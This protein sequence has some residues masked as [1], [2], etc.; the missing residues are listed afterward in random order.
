VK[1]QRLDLFG[2]KSFADRVSISFHSGITAIVGPNGCG[3]SNICDAIRWVLGEQR[4]TLVRGS[5]MD[6]VIFAGSRERKPINVAEIAL[7]FS[8]E[9]GTLPIEYSEVTIARRIF[10]G[11]GE[12]EYLLNRQPCRLK[13]VQ[14]L[15]LGTGIGTH[16]YSLIQQGMIDAVLSDRTEERRVLFEEAA[17]VTRYKTR[18]KATERKLEATTQDLLRVE[19][20][21][22]E[23][24]KTVGGLK[25]QVGKARRWREYEAEETR[26]DVHVADRDLSALGDRRAPLGEELRGLESA[27]AEQAA[28]LAEREAELETLELDLAQS[29]GEEQAARARLEDLRARIT[30]RDQS[31]LVTAETLAH[32]ARRIEALAA[33]DAR[34]DERTSELVERRAVLAKDRETA[35]ERLSRIV[36]RLEPQGDLELEEAHAAELKVERGQLMGDA[37][38]LQERHAEARQAAARRLSVAEAAAERH[39]ALVAESAEQARALEAAA[40][41]TIAAHQALAAAGFERDAAARLAEERRTA[42]REVAARRDATRDR[43]AD[44]RAAEG[45]AATRWETLA[46]MESRFEGYGSG[47]QALLAGETRVA[48]LLGALTQAV[49]P[50]EPRYERALDRY[51]ESLGHALLARDRAAATEGAERLA[52]SRA[53]R[54]D[55]LIPEFVANGRPPEIPD[56]AAAVVLA[57]GTEALRWIGDPAMAARVLPL[58]ARLLVVADRA[59]AFRCREALLGDEAAARY[60]VVAALDGSLLEPTGRWRPAGDEGEEGLLARRRRLAEAE[61]ELA[62]RREAAALLAREYEDAERS[63]AEAEATASAA[64]ERLAEADEARRGAREALA[65]GEQLEARIAERVAELAAAVAEQAR[66]RE[67]AETMRASAVESLTAIERDLAAARE[68][69]AGLQAALERYD[70]VRQERLSA[71]HAVQLERA[72]GEAAL[73]AVEREIEHVA[74]AE[75][76]LGQARDDRA[77]ERARIEEASTR[78]ES[79]SRATAIEIEALYAELDGVETGVRDIETRLRGMEERRGRA[80]GEIRILRRA[81][82]ESMEQRHQLALAIQDL[83]FR[84]EALVAHLA[85]NYDAPLAE[86]VES[87]PLAEDERA[88]SLEALKERLEEVRRRRANLG[89]VNM[90]AVEEYEREA[91]RLVFLQTQRDDLVQARRQLEEAIRRINDTARTLFLETFEQI[92]AHFEETFQVLFEGGHADIRLADPDDPLESPVEIVASPR[93][94]RVQHITLLSGGERALTALSLLFAIYRVKPSPFCILDEVDAPLDDANI[95]RFLKMIRHFSER[96]QFVV[97]THNKRTMEAADYLYGVTMEEPGISSI[98]S[99]SLG[100]EGSDE[101]EPSEEEGAPQKWVALAAG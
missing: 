55:F 77:V 41:T 93:G 65:V 53:G 28:R 68:R 27:E 7:H 21:V 90:L 88:L 14:D 84:R 98:V 9:D 94:K 76:A 78:L 64:T 42:L 83:E 72:E 39:A 20:I 34:S 81:H 99:V 75:E 91:E 50:S 63:V 49:E 17:G 22:A 5:K 92:R 12:S 4:P 33:E 29:H 51:L 61:E 23:V 10:R 45:A 18:R 3:K 101:S 97:I 43:V 59:A 6:E 73:R 80:E 47:A 8:N 32:H 1:L 58:F 24:E 60:F 11:E 54:A 57:R 16:A 48:G 95:A 19:D 25:R 44:V 46:A 62:A 15:F 40:A 67:D 26:L 82:D 38:A 52:E 66:V 79:E 31:R 70:E 69:L 89:P 2:F 71:R 36:A 56:G 86:L 96:T 37:E 85:Q 35:A 87:H 74:S 30:R 100:S 13:D